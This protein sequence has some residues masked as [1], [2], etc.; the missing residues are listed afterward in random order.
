MSRTQVKKI[1]LKYKDSLKKDNF[2]VKKLI[3]YGSYAKGNPAPYSD[4]DVC[5]ISDKFS[6]NRDHYENYL[7]RKV[8]DVDPRIEPVGYSTKGF[9]SIDPL[10]NEI[11]R[12]G[13][14]IK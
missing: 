8:L 1:L 5:V 10:V 12:H 7:W 14:E 11:K 3:L 4:I 13:V 6:R 9:K 2:P